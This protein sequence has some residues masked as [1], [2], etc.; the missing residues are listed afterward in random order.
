MF[1][2]RFVSLTA[3]QASFFSKTMV[4]GPYQYTLLSAAVLWKAWLALGV[5]GTYL[6]N[7]LLPLLFAVVSYQSTQHKKCPPQ[8][9]YARGQLKSEVSLHR[10]LLCFLINFQGKPR[11]KRRIDQSGG[12]CRREKLRRLESGFDHFPVARGFPSSFPLRIPPL[13]FSKIL[14]SLSTVLMSADQ[15]MVGAT[16]RGVPA[17]CCVTWLRAAPSNL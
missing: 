4:G 11:A 12:K 3:E 14:R 8:S 10:P 7:H 13:V 16:N 15:F 5:F 2:V 9:G 17:R 1:F 6:L